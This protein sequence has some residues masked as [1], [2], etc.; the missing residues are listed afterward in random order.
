M[1]RQ[2]DRQ[3]LKLQALQSLDLAR[4]SLRGGWEE[5]REHLRP[6]NF[7]RER[8]AKHKVA[9]L[10][11]A[12]ITGAL[13]TRW[14]KGFFRGP[15]AVTPARKRTI[16]GIVLGSLWGLAREPLIALATQ[17]VVPVIMRYFPQFQPPQNT[18]QPE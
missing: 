18:S 2:P 10:V 13:A 11:T 1:A 6:A 4:A 3:T 17:R 7:L 14:I 5:A 8:V 9:V 12:L 16:T 15:A